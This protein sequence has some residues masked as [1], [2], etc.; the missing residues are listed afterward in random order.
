M[1]NGDDLPES[2]T[3]H[4][5]GFSGV[6]ESSKW[7]RRFQRSTTEQTQLNGMGRSRVTFQLQHSL[8]L[9]F[10]LLV[11]QIHTEAGRALPTKGADGHVCVRRP[12]PAPIPLPWGSQTTLGGD[13]G[14]GLAQPRMVPALPVLGCDGCL[15]G[16]GG[17]A[18]RCLGAAFCGTAGP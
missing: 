17:S 13:A 14:V 16:A 8:I 9:L 15:G 1:G 7:D 10:S 6:L 18:L 4:R 12:C 5:S 3:W 11:V 2:H